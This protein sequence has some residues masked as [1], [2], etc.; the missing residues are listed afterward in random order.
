M[1]RFAI[2]AMALSATTVCA[3]P[4]VEKVT[5]EIDGTEFES[6]LIR[7]GDTASKRPG[8]V[9]VPN[10][11][12]INDTAIERA[13][14]IAGDRYVVLLADVYGTAVRPKDFDEAGEASMRVQG[15]RVL[16]RTRINRAVEAFRKAGNEWLVP[17]K[18]AAIGF[19]FGGTVALELAR[20]GADVAGVVSF[21]GNPGPVVP[22]EAGAVKASILVLHGADDFFVSAENLRAFEAEMKAA[23]AD[24]T[25]VSFSG[26]KHCFAESEAKNEPPGCIY[27]ARAARR[28][29][30]AMDGFLAEVFGDRSGM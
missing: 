28:A 20:S 26:A 15:D 27:N 4:V 22:A 14:K 13:K 8:V 30:A 11:L 7:D 21:H 9:M 6:L 5:Y 17:G 12:G 18:I 2:I 10:W 3:A 16:T 24:W 23:G 25:F 19:C 29:Y 1:F